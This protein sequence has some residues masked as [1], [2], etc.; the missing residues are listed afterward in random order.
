MSV[1]K[2]FQ[3]SCATTLCHVD[4]AWSLTQLLLIEGRGIPEHTSKLFLITIPGY[5]YSACPVWTLNY[6]VSTFIDV[7]RLSGLLLVPDLFSDSPAV[8]IGGPIPGEDLID[9]WAC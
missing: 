7:N 6:N 8:P 3:G 4:R 5:Y 9:F 2:Q 1:Q